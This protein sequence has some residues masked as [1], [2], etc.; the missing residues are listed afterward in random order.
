MSSILAHQKSPR[1]WAQMRGGGGELRGLS[2][3]VQLYKV[4]QLNFEDLN[5]YLT[6]D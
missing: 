3:W 5:P 4:A 1:I 2:Q 6:Y